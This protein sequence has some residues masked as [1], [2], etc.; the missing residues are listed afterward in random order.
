D[1]SS[2]RHCS[3]CV[4]AASLVTVRSA[5]PLSR[6][7]AGLVGAGLGEN[8]G[9]RAV[10]ALVPDHS[11]TDPQVVV[12]DADIAPTRRD[13]RTRRDNGQSLR[14]SGRRERRP[15]WVVLVPTLILALW[16]ATWV[17]HA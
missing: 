16:A 10:L 12:V 1:P 5:D 14:E 4:L 9:E 6:E 15:T 8:G 11:G 3:R 17:I 13:E 2:G 7:G